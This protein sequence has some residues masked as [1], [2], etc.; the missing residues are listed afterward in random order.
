M[1][2]ESFRS[3]PDALEDLLVA[4]PDGHVRLGDVARIEPRTGPVGIRHEDR[5]RQISVWSQ[6]VGRPLGHIVRDIHERLDNID[7]GEGY[8][9]KFRGFQEDMAESNEAASNIPVE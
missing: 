8:S 6:V 9:L 7:F 4:G 2:S 3:D 5:Q 1:L